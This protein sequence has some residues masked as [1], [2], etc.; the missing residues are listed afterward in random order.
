MRIAFVH[1]F[2][3]EY[4]GVMYLAA[5][6]RAAG[7]E[8]EVFVTALERNLLVELAR[9]GP[10]IAGFSVTTGEHVGMLRLAAR[11]RRDLG[12]A[13][14]FGGAHPTVCPEM[15][16]RDGVDVVC[17]GEG[18]DALLELA[19]A[20]ERGGD[21]GRI[22]NL[23]VKRDGE[24][25]RNEVRPLREDLEGLPRPDWSLYRKY[26][27]L[28]EKT[29]KTFIGSR[30]CPFRCT[31]CTDPYFRSLYRGKG[32]Y[33]R[34]RDP[35]SF[36]GE[37]AEQKAT[38]GFRTVTFDDEVFVWNREWL[39][40]FLPLYRERVG[41]PFFCGVRADTLTE[42]IVRDL[43]AAGCYGMSF[44]IESGSEFI[45]NGVGGK[46]VTNEQI[47]AASR[48]VRAEGIILRTTNM[49][50]MPAETPARAWETV[51]LNIACRTDHPFAYVYQPLPRTEMYEYARTH[52]HLDP[53][54]DFDRL[55]PMH[56][57]GNPLRLEGKG[58]ILNTQRLFYL[59][60]R[61]PRLA[62]LLRFLT[63]LPP[64][65]IFDFVFKLCLVRNYSRYK[66]LGFLKTLA[67]ALK[68][69]VIEQEVSP[70]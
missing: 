55:E 51:R 62:P 64:N 20:M 57:R 58:R 15:I 63:R 45:R 21:I 47:L 11:V 16:E 48:W 1:S 17:V 36:A 31:F 35:G 32:R 54:F 19:E 69:R 53:D 49:F 34:M 2:P 38:L 26:R 14:V 30:G 46:G 70:Q 5:V 56:L 10:R 3:Q 29:T 33:L 23:W 67:L 68:S 24:I 6:L 43:R 18:E 61:H 22:P 7:H 12:A 8:C 60:V 27:F 41:L 44:G 40:A 9:F 13:T 66:K 4:H 39:R 59:A 28:R 52:G 50:C 25:V 37:I 65:P 42:E